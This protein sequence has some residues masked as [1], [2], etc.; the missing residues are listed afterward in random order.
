MALVRRFLLRIISVFRHGHQERE[1]SR[2]MESHLALLEDD[3]MA[4]GMSAGDAKLAARKAIGGVE[5]AKELQRDARMFRW[6]NDL[7]RDAAYAVRSLRRSPA[8][9][10]AAVLTL[11]IGIGATTAI[12]SVINRVLLQPLPFPDGDRLVLVREP[13]RTPRTPPLTY[14]EYLEWRSR[15]QTLSGIAA[16]GLNPQV[17]MPTREGTARLAGGSHLDQLLSR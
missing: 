2:E 3:F 13:E 15:T 4:G 10:V 6:I 11:A 8:F 7:P 1:L 12:F 5:Q 17:I 14:A 16:I 9:T